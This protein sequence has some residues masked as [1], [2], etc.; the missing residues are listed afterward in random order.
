MVL[1]LSC[2]LRRQVPPGTNGALS[3]QG[4]LGSLIG[5]AWIGLVSS[6]SLVL[7]D[8]RGCYPSDSSGLLSSISSLS[9]SSSS[10]APQAPSPLHIIGSCIALGAAGGLGGSAIDSLLGA[11]LQRTWYN[12]K[13]G[14]VL[15]GRL[16]AA[17]N[18]RKTQSNRNKA[19]NA[20]MWDVVT[21]SDVLSN[22][23]VNVLSS[24]ATALLI[25]LLGSAL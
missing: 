25:A 18:E 4:T 11:T 16:P 19:K 15:V 22:S 3:L 2:F 23:A 8:S 6:V 17:A 20:G 13:T 10:L 1:P 5:G 12:A 21:G 24:S 14:Q 7:L 9:L